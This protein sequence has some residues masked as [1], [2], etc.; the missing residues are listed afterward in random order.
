MIDYKKIIDFWFE[1]LSPVQWFKKDQQLDSLIIKKFLSVHNFVV[2]GESYQW[3]EEPL[4]CLAE[5]IVMDQFS[6]NIFRGDSKSYLYDGMALVLSQEAI[7]RGED[8]NLPP[9]K[10]SFFYMPFMH[11]ESRIIHEKAVE[12]FSSDPEFQLNLKSEYEHK[13]IIDRFGRYPH[14]NK[15][16]GRKPTSEEITFLKENKSNFFKLM[17]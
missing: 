13:K 15:V 8:K 14:R 4:G 17:N 11:S 9:K 7:R 6:R 1:E 2:K 3:R 10:R 16:L 5:V 12:L